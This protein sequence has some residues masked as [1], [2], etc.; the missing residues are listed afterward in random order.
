LINIANYAK[1]FLPTHLLNHPTS[2]WEYLVLKYVENKPSFS[3]AN[4]ELALKRIAAQVITL[5]EKI[6]SRYYARSAICNELYRNIVGGGG[7]LVNLNFDRLPFAN[8]LLINRSLSGKSIKIKKNELIKARKSDLVLLYRRIK[9][10][11]TGGSNNLNTIIWHPHGCV[12]YPDTIRMGFRDY[13]IMPSYYIEAFKYFKAW[14]RKVLSHKVNNRDPITARD[15]VKL[16]KQLDAMD[17][18]NA[19]LSVEAADN[20]ITRFMLLPVSIVGAGLSTDEYGLRWLLIQ[21]NRNLA[22]VKIASREAILYNMQA[23]P[24][25][26][27][28]RGFT[29]WDSAWKS[30]LA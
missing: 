11:S 8:N 28:S 19:M 23:L 29:D 2:A 20:W 10:E 4:A 26:V 5:E 13:G 17:S 25:G 9:L 27:I 7:H 3:A 22:R 1:I 12:D 21:R 16:L 6:Q 30:A 18:D 14:Q 24:Q 15:H